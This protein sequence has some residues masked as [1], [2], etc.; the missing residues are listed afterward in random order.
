MKS[1]Q[2]IIRDNGRAGDPTRREPPLTAAPKPAA[3]KLVVL[4]PVGFSEGVDY[5][6][7]TGRAEVDEGVLT[8]FDSRGLVRMMRAPGEWFSVEYLD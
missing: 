5:G 8:V 7:F 6:S 3:R 2:E 4:F 1:L